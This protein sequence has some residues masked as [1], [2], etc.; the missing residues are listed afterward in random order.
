MNRR[1]F[2]LIELLVVIAIIGILA[3]VVLVAVGS[4]REK[5]RMAN[6]IS[7]AAQVHRALFAECASVWDFEE[8]VGNL[9]SDTCNSSVMGTV[10]GAV[11]V[12]GVNNGMALEFDGTNNDYVNIPDT[13]KLPVFTLSAWIFNV[14]GGDSRHSVLNSFWEVVGQNMCF[15]SYD[16]AN[17]YWRCSVGNKVEYDQWTHV[18]T[19]W[20]GSVIRHY[21]NGELNWTDSSVSSGTS[22]SFASIAGYSGRKFKGKLDDVHI[23]KED[24]KVAAIRQLYAQGLEKHMALVNKQD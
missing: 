16:F 20:D 2:T 18:V 7:Y 23:Y 15:W 14:A 8:I 22:Q 24:L 5:A 9:V 21:I 4:V 10:S 19:S 17:D 11:A 6:L 3:S 13:A 1:G 12:D